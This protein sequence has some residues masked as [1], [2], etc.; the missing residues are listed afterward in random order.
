MNF[1]H[2]V[3]LRGTSMTEAYPPKQTTPPGHVVQINKLGIYYEE[4]R[5][6]EPLEAIRAEMLK[7]SSELDRILWDALVS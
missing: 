1:Y 2:L 4:Y 7:V 3:D 6:G 5:V